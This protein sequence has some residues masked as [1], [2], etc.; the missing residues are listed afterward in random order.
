MVN[1][2][3]KFKEYFAEYTGNY[4]IIGGTACEIYEEQYAQRP[5][6]TKD[7]DIIL[8]VE[9]LS[10]DFVFK[11]WEFIQAGEYR[12][13]E[14]GE[15][16]FEYYRFLN[17]ASDKFPFQ[18]ELFSRSLS[19]LNFPKDAIITPIP[20]EDELSSLSAILM[21][22]DYYNFTIKH[23]TV[24]NAI[25]LANK[26]SLICLKAKAFLEMS[27]RKRNGEVMDSKHILKHKKDVFRLA[28]MLAP[29]DNYQLPPSLQKDIS[30]FC[31]SVSSDLPNIDFFKSIGLPQITGKILLAQL[32]NS[33]RIKSDE[34]YQHP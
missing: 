29:G 10:A 20:V 21:D 3:E 4:V 34:G 15:N 5:R 22:D 11:F 12:M 30:A 27:E 31:D 32:K 7:I 13:R 14:K 25:H 24:D 33:F 28:A 1:G 16:E 18:I 8:I 19:L 26:E 23:S 6:A 2:I 17:P 9:A